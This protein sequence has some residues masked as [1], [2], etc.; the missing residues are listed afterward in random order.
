MSNEK[1]SVRWSNHICMVWSCF[2]L[3]SFCV[4]LWSCDSW[5]T[6]YTS[7]CHSAVWYQMVQHT[8]TFIQKLCK[9]GIQQVV[10]HGNR[11][12]KSLKI[13]WHGKVTYVKH[14]CT[15]S[16]IWNIAFKLFDQIFEND[17]YLQWRYTVQH[18]HHSMQ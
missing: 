12:N 5:I 7:R 11:F 3:L 2:V 14:I 9:S 8:L 6:L 1:K 15:I 4:S 18:I 17:L 13:T 10:K 16:P